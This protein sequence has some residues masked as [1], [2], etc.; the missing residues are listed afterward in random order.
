MNSERMGFAMVDPKTDSADRKGN[1]ERGSVVEW[2]R[3][4]KG[5]KKWRWKWKKGSY[6]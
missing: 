6:A 3:K 4:K 1:G 5:R 2:E